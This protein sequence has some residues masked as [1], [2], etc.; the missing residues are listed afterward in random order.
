MSGNMVEAST[1]ESAKE[2]E[3]PGHSGG[4]GTATRKDAEEA[5]PLTAGWTDSTHSTEN[6]YG[7]LHY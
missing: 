6:R 5:Q 3:W 2:Q 4:D 7:G 1:N